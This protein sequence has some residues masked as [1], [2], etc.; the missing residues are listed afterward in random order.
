MRLRVMLGIMV[1]VLMVG[2][3]PEL[4]SDGTPLEGLAPERL[5]AMRVEAAERG[6]GL[7]VQPFRDA[8][9]S[10]LLSRAD[11]AEQRGDW[12]QV[13][14][15]L[16]R[17]GEVADGDDP[18]VLQ[19]QAELA[20]LM[21]EFDQARQLAMRSFEY[22]PKAGPLCLRNFE[23]VALQAELRRD[24][25]EADQARERQSVCFPDRPPRL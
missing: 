2:C 15:W 13:A 16:A 18:L 20:L 10:A 1:V 14:L 23:T 3:Q 7:D 12:D 24:P 5:V 25:G 22:G 9:V 8:G 6:R 11:A 19:R 17:A 21:A 4:R